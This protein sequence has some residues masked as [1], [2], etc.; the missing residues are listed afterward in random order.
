MRPRDQ[1]V[2]AIGDGSFDVLVIGGGITGAGVALDAASRGCSVALVEQ[3]DYAS[4]TSGR[5]SKLIHGGL[6]YLESFNFG[7]VLEALRERALLAALAP[8]LVRP[9]PLVVPAFDG[10]HPNRKIGLGLSIYDALAGPILRARRSRP[11][12]R[13]WSP[14][15]HRVISGERVAQLA[16]ALAPRRPTSGYLYHDCQSDDARLVL[17]VL[18]V[19]ERFGAVF[20]NRL[21]VTGLV[22]ERGRV[23]GATALDLQGGSELTVRARNVVSATGVW[24][25]RVG[26]A[27]QRDVRGSGSDRAAAELPRLVP[28]RGAHVIVSHEDLPLR[29]GVI[30]PAPDG[31]SLFALPWLGRSLIGTTDREHDGSLDHP[32]ASAEDIRYLLGPVNRLF[33]TDLDA[34]RLTGAYAGV[35]PL[36]ASGDGRASVDISRRE[37]LYETSDGLITITG[38]KLTTW[39]RMAKLTVDRIAARERR[40][41]A[42]RTH[43]IPLGKPVDADLLPRVEGVA[44][45]A[46]GAL[47]GR[48][49]AAAADVLERAAERPELAAPIVLGL[50]DLLA[51]AVH[52]AAVEQALTVSD[53]LLRRTRLGLLAARELCAAGAR[54]PRRV[55]EAMAGTLGWDAARVETEAARFRDEAAIEGLVAS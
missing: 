31:R 37:R 1:A 5:S 49:G 52:A 36:V 42:C 44:E 47:A 29:A 2:Q 39:R 15:R 17:T 23:C 6:R 46:Y 41:A 20:A 32:Q 4:G 40:D 22:K 38:G 21:R 14:S 3:G 28:S 12:G 8:H 45:G 19:A 26:V 53:V 55:A 30:V 25:D 10:S 16:P 33:G 43:R 51:E 9:L 48:Y 27:G 35:R 34:S 13:G 50:P 7:L 54:G 18:G 11:A 24:A